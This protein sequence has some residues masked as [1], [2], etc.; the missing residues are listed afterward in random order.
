MDRFLNFQLDMAI[1][2]FV[3]ED[4]YSYAQEADIGKA[5]SGIGSKIANGVKAI[6]R[7]IMQIIDGLIQMFRRKQLKLPMNVALSVGEI[8]K[9]ATLLSKIPSYSSV[10][11]KDFSEAFERLADL[12]V[13]VHKHYETVKSLTGNAGENEPKY[14]ADGVSGLSANAAIKTLDKAKSKIKSLHSI[15]YGP[16]IAAGEHG[17]AAE[18]SV[19]SDETVFH[20]DKINLKNGT[21]YATEVQKICVEAAAAISYAS[22]EIGDALRAAKLDARKT[23]I[24]SF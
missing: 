4:F 22:K 17:S 9:I 8:D 11:G 15:I 5:L 10:I 13:N 2:S 20:G 7:K 16:Y 21:A 3:S 24:D 23:E 6:G 18:R 12:K 14:S 1:E 19:A